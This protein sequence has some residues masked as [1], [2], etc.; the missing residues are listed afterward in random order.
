MGSVNPSQRY[1]LIHSG[2]PAFH[3]LNFLFVEAIPLS[4]GPALI[5]VACG[6]TVVDNRATILHYLGPKRLV[7]PNE[8]TGVKA[9]LTQNVEANNE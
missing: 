9:V 2:E 3:D 6:S 8:L 4:T 7:N 1:I 5:S